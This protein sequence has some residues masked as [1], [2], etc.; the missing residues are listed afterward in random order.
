MANAR[1]EFD[2]NAEVARLAI[3]LAF[4][5]EEGAEILQ[6]EIQSSIREDDFPAAAGAP[7]HSAGAYRESWRVTR[8]KRKGHQVIAWTYSLALAANGQSLA[9]ILE[10][11][12]GP[13]SPHP[14]Y[15]P[16]I[17]R[18]QRRFDELGRRE[19]VR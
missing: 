3:E 14:H 6:E 8:A 12:E 9:D 1:V 11:G 13:I 2:V 19:S 18:A 10:T 16:A 15:R 17:P 7:P 4:L 5:A